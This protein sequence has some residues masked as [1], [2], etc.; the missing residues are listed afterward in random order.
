MKI[1]LASDLH[2]EH[3]ARRFPG[4]T[5]IR[6][7]HQADVLVLAGDIG[8]AA[9]AIALFA[10]WPVPVLYV[11]G[12]HE[13]YGGCIESILDELKAASQGTSVWFLERETAEFGGVRFLGCTLW[14]D[15]RLPCGLTQSKLMEN[16]KYRLNDHRLIRTRNGDLFSPEHALRDH[17]VSRTWLGQE[18]SKVYDGRTVVITHHAP[19][20]LSVH[21]RYGGDATNASFASDLTELVE[22]AN[23]W[24]HGH[25]HD[26][27]DYR[28]AGCRV[29]ANPLGYAL[30]ISSAPNAGSLQF[31]NGAFQNA[32]VVDTLSL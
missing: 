25:V 16:A 11:L 22:L 28:V 10:D 5:L 32:C 27:V 4:E 19:H 12:N 6:P 26:S 7:A 18:L 1:Q 21:P 29:V 3:L 17:E 14:T 23:L 30:N 13:A 15:Y 20:P 8:H 31:E 9:D 2:L 24:L